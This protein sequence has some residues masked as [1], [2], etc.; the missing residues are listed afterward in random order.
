MRIFNDAIENSVGVNSANGGEFIGVGYSL[1]TPPANG[2]IIQGNVGIGTTNTSQSLSVQGNVLITGVTTYLNNIVAPSISSISNI[3]FNINTQGLTS[4]PGRMFWDVNQQE[5]AVSLLYNG[6]V[7]HLGQDQVQQIYNNT[8]G[9][10]GVGTVV[11][12]NG[13]YSGWPTVS[14]ADAATFLHGVGLGIIQVPVG[15]NSYGYVHISGP[16]QMNTIGFTTGPLYLSTTPGILTSIQPS[17]PNFSVNFAY[18]LNSQSNGQIII[19]PSSP[20]RVNQTGSILFADT[21]GKPGSSF[22]SF[23]IDVAGGTYNV[24]IG[25]NVAPNRLSVQGSANFAGSVSISTSLTLNAAQGTPAIVIPNSTTL[26]NNLNAQLWNGN[27]YPATQAG[28]MFYASGVGGSTL[29]RIPPNTSTGLQFL[30]QAGTG[31]T[32]GAPSWQVL[33]STGFLNYF[34]NGV[35]ATGVPGVFQLNPIEPIGLGTLTTVFNSSGTTGLGSFITASGVPNLLYLPAGNLTAYIWSYQTA[36]QAGRYASIIATFYEANG[37]GTVIGVIGTT[38]SVTISG[39]LNQYTL[40]YSQSN[41]YN[42][43]STSS[44]IQV[45]INATTTGNTNT[46]LVNYGNSYGSYV[47]ISAPGADVTNFVPYSGAVNSV[48]LGNFP[49]QANTFDLNTAPIGVAATPGRI[50]WNTIFGKP[51]VGLIYNNETVTLGINALLVYN[52]TGS[53]IGV[54][55]V[56]YV[57]GASIVNPNVAAAALADCNVYTHSIAVGLVQN[58]IG[59]GSYGYIRTQGAVNFDT[60]A[61]N[62]GDIVY[63]SPTPGI[64]T[65]IAPYA[66]Y[67]SIPVGICVNSA[68]NGSVLVEPQSPNRLNNQGAVLFANS[69][70]LPLGYTSQFFINDAAGSYALGIGTTS[71]GARLEINVANYSNSKAILLR[72]A[73]GQTANIFE[74]RNSNDVVYNSITG[75]GSVGIG[76][77][78]PT[79]ALHIQ[80]N[81]RIFG[82]IYDSSNNIGLAGS[83]LSS[84][85]SGV[86]WTAPGGTG[87][88][89]IGGSISANQIAYGQSANTIAGVSTF[90]YVNNNVGIGTATPANLLT[91]QGDAL[92]NGITVGIGSYN[93]N[94]NTVFGYQAAQY[95]QS[96]A[97][98]AIGYQALQGS[99]TTPNLATNTVAIGVYA[100]QYNNAGGNV[101]IGLQANA[102]ST[103]T[104]NYTS[105]SVTLGY[106]A[107]Q[108]ANNTRTIAIGNQVMGGGTATTTIGSADSIVMG[109]QA[110]QY[111]T[112]GTNVVIGNYSYQGTATTLNT[113]NASVAIGYAAGRYLT[114][115]S[116]IAIGYQA[117]QG[118]SALSYVTVN[119]VA[120]GYGAGLYNQSSSNVIIGYQALIGTAT[121]Y[122]TGGSNSIVGYLAGQYLTSSGNTIMGYAA[123]QGSATTFLTA[124]NLTAFGYLAA[125]YAQGAG[126]VALGWSAMAAA[127]VTGT[128]NIAI[129]YNA[130]LNLSSGSNNILL[131]YNAGSSTTTA[132][133]QIAIGVGAQPTASNL[134]SWGANSNATRTDLGIGTYTPLSRTHIETLATG[135]KGLYI[136]GQPSQTANLLQIDATTSG[137]NLVTVTGIGSVGIGTAI[138]TQLLHIQGNTR[139][140]G[141]I[142]DS[143]NNIGLAGSVLSSTGTGIAWTTPG[144]IGGSISANQ[145]AYGL[146]TNSITG[147]NNLWFTGSTVG[148]GTSSALFS[149]PESLAIKQINSNSFSLITGVGSVNNYLQEIIINNSTGNNASSDIVVQAN[150]GSESAYYLDLGIN[151]SGYSQS[152]QYGNALDA[153]LYS[154]SNNLLIANASLGSSIVFSTGTSYFYNQPLLVMTSG[155]LPTGLGGSVGINTSYPTQLLH[156][157][158]NARLTGALYDINNLP[159]APIG[160]IT[161]YLASTG[162]GVT[163]AP[164]KRSLVTQ[165]MSAYTPTVTGI[166]AG[167]FIVP[168]DPN[169]GVSTMNF[170][171]KRVNVR[172]ETPST[173]ISTINIVKYIGVGSALGLQTAM[174][175]SNIQITG[176]STFEGFSTSFVL[177]YSTCASSDKLAVNFVG[178]STFHTNFTV[179]LIMRET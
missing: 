24:G 64:L 152:G 40:V 12:Y 139:H 93:N 4:V 106:I 113:G 179:E 28:D 44:R 137:V 26:I 86:A 75:L 147:S 15:I 149:S 16:V 97:G 103:A 116:N 175:A 128:Y 168:Q 52:G 125:R 74:V 19:T 130:G 146:G 80:G 140:T 127:V 71:P 138:P 151:N 37:F 73:L 124:N 47:N 13:V 109:F 101:I 112:G 148:I 65:N 56:A 63:V 178:Y 53:V 133:Y 84:T 166:D 82:G 20:L 145:I 122:N 115:S 23:F 43:Q 102:G 171:M 94:T 96:T 11:Y 9:V 70:G 172:V 59:I 33:P 110:G 142:Y 50:Y 34:L 81:T 10:L 123:A 164:V 153:Y 5:L 17:Y 21:Q 131:G 95:F 22:S 25:T 159:G 100:G 117:L 174:L 136:A 85:G 167:M 60:R 76:T 134:G 62:S 57:S 27:T 45:N 108:F 32:A 107:A 160:I 132:T 7:A 8:G 41:L 68:A 54:G 55:S 18:A 67:F 58:A 48:N 30:G 36:T 158:G 157:Q 51:T 69:Q 66:P 173:G 77:F 89:T 150:T 126:N 114:G 118:Q 49:I 2:L 155:P 99:A 90:V 104:T 3:D 72:S 105:A 165:L 177:G 169:D 129:G 176:S 38:N 144:T 98:V 111:L 161:Q 135:N 91:V 170:T 39:S 162:A 78:V 143:N 119:S 121:T 14:L 6:E 29:T 163:W 83:V 35:A 120:I 87:S 141:G 1:F 156:V 154:T 61:F 31:T 92:I 46:I 88:G 42:F 79:Q